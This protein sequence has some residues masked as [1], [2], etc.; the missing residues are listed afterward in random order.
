M[1]F[2]LSKSV[3]Y[4]L[5]PSN[6]LFVQVLAGVLPIGSVPACWSTG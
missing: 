3:V 2:I 5:L 4:L 6:F 1:F